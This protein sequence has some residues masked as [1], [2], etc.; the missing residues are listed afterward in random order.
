MDADLKRGIL[1]NLIG[2]IIVWSLAPA[3]HLCLFAGLACGINWLVFLLHAW[4][5]NSEKFFDATG[6]ITY[7]AMVCTGLFLAG[8]SHREFRQIVNPV[9][10]LIWCIR[11]GSYLFARIVQD[12]KDSRFDEFKKSTLR[13]LSVWTI[14]ALWCFLVASPALVVVSSPACSKSSSWPDFVGWGLWSLGFLFEVVADRQKDAFRRDP[15][16]RGQFIT[17]G[18]WAYSRHPNYFG[19]ITMWVGL[20][21]TGSSCFQDFQWLAWLSPVITWILLMKVTGVPL[22]EEKG[23]QKWG[24]E[25]AYKWYMQNTPCIV[26]ALRKPPP[27]EASAYVKV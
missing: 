15:V 2:L 5:Q 16:N 9:M 22:L 6:S 11:L 14:Q 26:S 21:I 17:V 25:P 10:V 12:G 8:V 4:P 1:T 27:F 20:C 3:M 13:F 19:E 18:L 7:F 24:H 23:E